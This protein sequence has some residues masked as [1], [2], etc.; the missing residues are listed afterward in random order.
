MKPVFLKCGDAVFYLAGGKKE[1]AVKCLA[2]SGGI[3]DCSMSEGAGEKHLPIVESDGSRITVRVGSIEH[4]MT[5]EHSI[6]W[7]FLETEKGGQFAYLDAD[8]KP[9]AEFT[10]SKG[11]KALAAYAYCNLHGFWKT[12]IK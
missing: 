10:L 9:L 2:P 12:E 4:P 11:D 7:V 3:L 8:K 1:E 6:Q 5:Q